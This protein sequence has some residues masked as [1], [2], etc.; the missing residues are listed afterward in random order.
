VDDVVEPPNPSGVPGEQLVVTG[1]L[2]GCGRP[3]SHYLSRFLSA[4]ASAG[5]R[6]DHWLEGGAPKGQARKMFGKSARLVEAVKKG[7]GSVPTAKVSCDDIPLEHE[8][9]LGLTRAP[10]KL[11]EAAS[12]PSSAALTART[13]WFVLPGKKEPSR[14]S[15]AAAIHLAPAS[16]SQAN[17]CLPR[18]SAVLFDDAGVAR[19]RYHAD[20]GG[21]LEVDVLGDRCQSLELRLEAQTQSFLA[22]PRKAGVGCAESSKP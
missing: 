20:F 11:C 21:Q 18:I 2:E 1:Q 10:V 5:E 12:A 22:W 8:W 16:A 9:K 14:A 19:F 6:V 7:R 4:A 15:I 13:Y 3:L 17:R